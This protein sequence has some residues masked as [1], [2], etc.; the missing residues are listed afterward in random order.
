ML[1]QHQKSNNNLSQFKEEDLDTT[2]F[3]DSSSEKPYKRLEREKKA[4]VE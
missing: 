4:E 2:T 1:N 3:I